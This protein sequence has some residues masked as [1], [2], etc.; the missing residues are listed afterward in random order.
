MHENSKSLKKSIL[1]VAKSLRKWH[2]HCVCF[3]NATSRACWRHYQ[4]HVGV[5]FLRLLPY[6][7]LMLMSLFMMAI[8]AE[9]QVYNSTWIALLKHGFMLVKAWLLIASGTG[10][11]AMIYCLGSK[12]LL[13]Y[14]P[15]RFEC[16]S[17]H[18]SVSASFLDSNLSS[19]NRF[20]SNFA[21]TLISGRSGLRLQMG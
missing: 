14:P 4:C 16:P 11:Y 3:D 10:F 20:S 19:F 18:P 21:W 13:L 8:K 5:T 1:S 17:I 12:Q 7:L 2:V 6:M 9:K 15:N